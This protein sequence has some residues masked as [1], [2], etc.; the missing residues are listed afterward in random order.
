MSSNK[1]IESLIGLIR[2][3]ISG[4]HTS[5]PGKIV[6]YANGRATVQPAIKFKVTNSDSIDAPPIVNV[7]VYF[8]G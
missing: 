2:G 5:C 7:P 6:N 8:P 4:I 1:T 3:E